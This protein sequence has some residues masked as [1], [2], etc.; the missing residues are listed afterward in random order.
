MN[1]VEIRKAWGPTE[2]PSSY[3]KFTVKP[4]PIP[5]DWVPYTSPRAKKAARKAKVLRTA[6]VG[7]GAAAGAAGL[8]AA[9]LAA[10]RTLRKPAAKAAPS[11]AKTLAAVGAGGVTA[12]LGGTLVARKRK[13][14]SD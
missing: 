11:G 13:D 4:G 5:S 8:G 1:L 6:K 9:A 7:G 14:S 10:S 3:P 2:V 12:G